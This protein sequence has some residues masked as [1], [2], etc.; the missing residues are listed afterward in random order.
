MICDCLLLFQFLCLISRESI[1]FCTFYVTLLNWS[2]GI[3]VTWVSILAYISNSPAELC[4]TQLYSFSTSFS[5]V[6]YNP[7]ILKSHTPLSLYRHN[8][9][10]SVAD[11][12][13]TQLYSIIVLQFW[14]INTHGKSV[15]VEIIAWSL[16]IE[17]TRASV[18]ASA[19]LD[20]HR[21]GALS[22]TITNNNL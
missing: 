20:V 14:I 11:L 22:H 9:T 8:F 1:Q 4:A 17:V 6:T 21:N 7:C 5:C 13:A 10:Y 18:L 16:G 3:K 19:D 15:F 2:L 12:C